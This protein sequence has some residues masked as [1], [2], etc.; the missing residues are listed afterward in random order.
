MTRWTLTWLL[1]SALSGCERSKEGG[2]PDD[3]DGDGYAA[4]LDCDDL[5]AGVSPEGVE[6][7]NGLDDDCD[8]LIDEPGAE[9]G[10][11][12]FI[13]EDGDGIGTGDAV[14]V[15]DGVAGGSLYPGD[16]DDGDPTI[17]PL[18]VERCDDL[19]ND[20]DG[21]TDEPGAEGSALWPVDADG[22][23]YGH[24]LVTDLACGPGDGFAEDTTDCDDGDPAR[25]PGA[26]ES[27]VN[28]QD[29]D[30]DGVVDE[31]DDPRTPTWHRDADGDG[32]G[33]SED[34]VT[35]ACAPPDGTV[36]S[37]GDCDD[38]DPEIHPAQPDRNDDLDNDCDGLVDERGDSSGEGRLTYSV[39]R[40]GSACELVWTMRWVEIDPPI[41]GDYT[42]RAEQTW[43]ERASS[44]VDNCD[45]AHRRE[46]FVWLVTYRWDT[47]G[48]EPNTL[49]T[50][51]EG[52]ALWFPTFSA[53]MNRSAGT[54]RFEADLVTENDVE[55]RFEGALDMLGM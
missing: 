39:S 46:D 2:A 47:F 26:A 24:P 11:V 4:D 28:G 51:E 12:G 13:D 19:D 45:V 15:C 50:R 49:W 3:L 43:D 16:C 1:L 53:T 30:C 9:D 34:T 42:W 21:Q 33:T 8:G 7:C 54:F 44:N 32:Y 48:L 36:L 20:C 41:M 6:R 40:R 18:A 10:L 29:D 17:S 23:G 27:C 25:S 52:S 35:G 37:D 31:T 55:A 14:S 5:A 38:L 22:D